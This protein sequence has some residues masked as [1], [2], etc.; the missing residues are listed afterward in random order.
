[1]EHFM[2]ESA[3]RGAYVAGTVSSKRRIKNV[4]AAMD[5]ALSAFETTDSI[6]TRL[7][8]RCA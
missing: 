7:P 3:H 4:A 5:Q 6:L 1:M 2:L 8:P